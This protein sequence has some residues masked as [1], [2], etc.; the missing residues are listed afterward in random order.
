VPKT[1]QAALRTDNLHHDVAP[2]SQEKSLA[3][4]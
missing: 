2:A 4:T 1:V 3:V